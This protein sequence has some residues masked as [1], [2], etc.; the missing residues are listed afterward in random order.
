[1]PV[2][3]AF[4]LQALP[5]FP[6][7]TVLK[8]F[9]NEQFAGQG[10]LPGDAPVGVE[11]V[12]NGVVPS[13]G[14]V[15]FEGLEPDSRYWVGALVDGAWA[16]KQ[17]RSPL[18]S[19]S[20]AAAGGAVTTFN[21]RPGPVLLPQ[22]G[23]YTAGMVGAYPAVEEAAEIVVAGNVVLPDPTLV[24]MLTLKITAP[25]PTVTFWKALKGR[26]QLIDVEQDTSGNR[27]PKWTP[28]AGDHIAY[29]EFTPFTLSTT[30]LYRDK[31]VAQCMRDGV[32]DLLLQ[33]KHAA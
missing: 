26:T 3:V 9:P 19:D 16:W 20:T 25:A 14:I 23:D 7:G 6:V 31:L 24:Q 33:G 32:I 1:M 8:V 12:S 11:E 17:I 29:I 22:T 28:A 4:R 21:G 15:I 18:A 30:P 10:P 2:T 5:K 27:V 13:R